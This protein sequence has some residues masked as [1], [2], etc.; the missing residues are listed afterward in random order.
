MIVL[1]P[2]SEEPKW[3]T[4]RSSDTILTDPRLIMQ[5]LRG[6]SLS[7][8]TTDEFKHFINGPKT[9]IEGSA[10]DWWAKEDQRKNYPR[11]SCLAID[12]LSVAPTSDRPE[13]VFSENRRILRWDRHKLGDLPLN[14]MACIKNWRENGHLQKYVIEKGEKVLGDAGIPE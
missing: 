11:L 3:K 14:N 4:Q 5:Q 13:R 2:K 12:I 10:L 7:T 6:Q 1:N 9:E 8:T